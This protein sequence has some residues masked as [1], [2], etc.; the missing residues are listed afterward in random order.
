MYLLPIARVLIGSCYFEVI[1]CHLHEM[2]DKY[3]VW[4]CLGF[5]FKERNLLFAEADISK[6]KLKLWTPEGV[7]SSIMAKRVFSLS[8]NV[9]LGPYPMQCTVDLQLDNYNI[10][11]V[12]GAG[13]WIYL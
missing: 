11:F 4:G 13:C 2:V 1:L 5:A 12:D 9:L 10:M 7:C 3:D 6:E 8:H